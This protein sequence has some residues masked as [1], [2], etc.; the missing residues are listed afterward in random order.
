MDYGLS[1]LTST[2]TNHDAAYRFALF[3]M[4]PQAQGI[5]SQYGFIT[6]AEVK[7]NP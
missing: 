2:A 7:P 4:S 5:I 1:V 3:I 6:V